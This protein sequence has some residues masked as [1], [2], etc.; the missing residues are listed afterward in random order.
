MMTQALLNKRKMDN[1]E[2]DEFIKSIKKVSGKRSHRI[3]NSY[4]FFFYY[5][6]F[7]KIKPNSKEYHIGNEL[8]SSIINSMNS[9]IVDRLI[10]SGSVKLPCGLGKLSI[11][12]VKNES[13]ID[14][15]GKLRTNR[16]V[17]MMS[18]LKLWYED[19]ESRSKKTLV[20]FDDEYTFKIVFDKRKA[21][22]KNKSYLMFSPNRSLKI[23]L[24][25]CIKN[26][27]YDAY[28]QIKMS[29]FKNNS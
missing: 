22:F 21:S 27:N 24:K 18:T 23:K 5:R 8:Y 25:D 26:K 19:D 7:N 15:N 20:R 29:E 10:D 14:K 16:K 17:D 4:G 11:L 1:I 3:V 28:E 9:M 6:H 12:K 13:W 2:F